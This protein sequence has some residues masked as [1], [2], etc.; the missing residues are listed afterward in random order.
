MRI[1]DSD[2]LVDLYR[3]AGQMPPWHG[4]LNRVGD[5][6]KAVLIVLPEAAKPPAF[7][8][9]GTAQDV[10]FA[11]DAL[12][13]MRYQRVYAAEELLGPRA[14]QFGRVLRVR[15]DRGGDAWLVVGRD[16]AEFSAAFTLMISGLGPHLAVAVGIYLNQCQIREQAALA[17][18]LAAKIQTGILTLTGAGIIQTASPLALQILANTEPVSGQVGAKLWLPTAAGKI[19]ADTLDDYEKGL[20]MGAVVLRIAP[21]QMLIQPYV[22]AVDT[23]QKPT[24][25][26]H[27][28][29]A[30][31]P[32]APA[33]KCLAQLA[34]ITLSEAR[35]ALKLVEGMTIA[36]AGAALGLSLETARNYSK[37]IYSKMGLR[38]QSDLIRFVQHSVIPLI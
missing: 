2:I 23:P 19:L 8:M 32:L 5:R 30:K 9:F 25:L 29:L 26:V 27:L 1:E 12:M 15:V 3:G 4:F 18:R 13:R 20:D 6:A 7:Q 28:R 31:P 11:A 37:Q 33:E 38:G 10:P 34:H 16:G 36:Q 17:D 21:V 24:A 35:F 22:G 14:F